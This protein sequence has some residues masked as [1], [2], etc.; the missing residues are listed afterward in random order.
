MVF[1]E[2]YTTFWVHKRS[3]HSNPNYDPTSLGLRITILQ[4][5]MITPI[6][7]KGSSYKTKQAKIR[8][9]LKYGKHYGYDGDYNRVIST[10]E[11]TETASS[12]G[13]LN[14]TSSIHI[15]SSLRCCAGLTRTLYGVPGSSWG[16][17]I[18]VTGPGCV[19]QRD[20]SGSKVLR[21]T[22]SVMYTAQWPSAALLMDNSA[23]LGLAFKTT[24]LTA[25]RECETPNLSRRTRFVIFATFTCSL[26]SL[27]GPCITIC[28]R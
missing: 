11:L 24:T 28:L 12:P 22:S 13:V 18:Q 17:V 16:T 7:C 1:L 6:W 5:H 15:G 9:L 8:K 4:V 3:N 20:S 10:S 26:E 23:F 21:F 27:V 25:P 14:V 19:C 2:A